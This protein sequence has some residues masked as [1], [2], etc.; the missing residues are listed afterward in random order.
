[1]SQFNSV[2][3]S[4]DLLVEPFDNSGDW[5]Q[6]L[7]HAGVTEPRVRFRLLPSRAIL[8]A[9]VISAVLAAAAFATGLAD[10][11]SSWVSGSPGEPAPATDQRGF[12][13]RN[14][15]SLASFPEGTQLRLLL[16]RPVGGTTFN[17]FGF[18]NGD[19]YCLR[20]ARADRPNGIG[21]NECLRAEELRG[22]AALV[23]DDAYFSVGDPAQSVRG[24]FGF[25]ND[26]VEAVSVRRTLGTERVP[27][28]NNV[29]LTLKAQPSG[30]VQRHPLP[31][32]VLA[33][34]ALLDDG[35]RR[36]I[37]YVVEGQG[38]FP[39]G[40]VLRAP[41]YFGRGQGRG[42]KGPS[43][44]EAPIENPKIGWLEQ[45]EERGTALGQPRGIQVEFG[46]VIQPDP[47][48]PIRIGVA[49]A[50]F[51][52]GRPPGFQAQRGICVITFA[53][54]ARSAGSSG[55][56]EEPFGQGAL[57]LGPTLGTPILHL[58]G[59]APDGI[60]H[61]TAYLASGRTVEAALRDN[62]F[63]V[64]VP[65]ADMPARLVGFDDRGRV[66]A[67]TEFPGNAVALPCPPAT[68]PTP[69]EE[70]PAP[71][72]WERIDLGS[73]TVAGEPILG[74]TPDEVRAALGEPTR[75]IAAA[76]RTNGVAIPEF[77]YGG[78]MPADVG[79]SIR[80]FKK[81]DKIY[82]NSLLYQSPSLVD[83]KLGHVLREQP[84]E[85]QRKVSSTYGNSYRLHRGY[86]SDP[87][88]GCSGTFLDRSSPAG[89]SFGVNPHRPS[90]PFLTI[91]TNGASG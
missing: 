45:R 63:G 2:A 41:S 13:E 34:T 11:F 8:L 6:I 55:C 43:V 36:N 15:V 62:V 79:L 38:V 80:F 27:V 86:G 14:E 76:Q 31:D 47:D 61:V 73:M 69:T 64:A 29:F 24:V 58:S 33:L 82:A 91:R 20:L 17:L 81:G 59:I 75:V 84:Q 54:L 12:E 3:E 50:Q 19:A 67:I 72:K 78:E 57:N 60:T 51:G 48:N 10:Q 42:L 71:R 1:M 16:S 49:K 65:Q 28:E 18:R 85:L 7:R 89:M 30:T 46:R 35:K 21:R 25:A 23:A 90:R 74:R 22:R 52:S 5:Q 37:P 39:N 70:L 66:A 56:S 77:R 40:Q 9:A 87:L 68:L 53:P 4:L 88:V 26:D 32:H 44:V 83:A